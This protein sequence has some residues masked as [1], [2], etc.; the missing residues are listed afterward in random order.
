[1]KRGQVKAWKMIREKWKAWFPPQYKV[2][3]N[4]RIAIESD[5]TP[6]EVADPVIVSYRQCLLR[7]FRMRR[8]TPGPVSVASLSSMTLQYSTTYIW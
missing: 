2:F 1:M 5:K 7:N 8:I 3:G 6:S 4:P